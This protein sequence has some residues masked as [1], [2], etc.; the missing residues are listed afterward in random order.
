MNIPG[1]LLI[2]ISLA[3]LAGQIYW[4]VKMSA[5]TKFSSLGTKIGFIIILLYLILAYFIYLKYFG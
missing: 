3:T 5:R 1:Y 2:A 4:F